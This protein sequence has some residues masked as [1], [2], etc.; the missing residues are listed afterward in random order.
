LIEARWDARREIYV[1]IQ[2]YHFNDKSIIPFYLSKIYLHLKLIFM[3]Q[4]CV[5]EI[6]RSLSHYATNL[7]LIKK[8]ISHFGVYLLNVEKNNLLHN[9]SLAILIDKAGAETRTYVNQFY[10]ICANRRHICIGKKCPRCFAYLSN[11]LWYVAESKLVNADNA[12]MSEM[13]RK[14]V[15]VFMHVEL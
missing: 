13:P 6:M 8:E 10:R 1:E 7:V 2:R 11:V 12:K 9:W 14:C 15:F 5:L 3:T 4:I